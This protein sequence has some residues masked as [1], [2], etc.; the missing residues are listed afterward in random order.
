MRIGAQCEINGRWATV[1]AMLCWVDA[2]LMA[3]GDPL[4]PCLGLSIVFKPD[5]AA[6]RCRMRD[7]A[8]DTRELMGVML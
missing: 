5:R 7:R 4:H 3:V 8:V 2:L 1:H 6:G